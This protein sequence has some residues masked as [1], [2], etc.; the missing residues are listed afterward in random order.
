MNKNLLIFLM[1][2]VSGMVAGIS[3]LFP[4]ANYFI[5]AALTPFFLFIYRENKFWRLWLGVFLYSLFFS[6]II[7]SASVFEPLFILS[8]A[9]IY[10]LAGIV[11]WGV[12]KIMPPLFFWLTAPFVFVFFEF[13]RSSL[14]FI[15]TY[16]A[17]VGY[18]LGSTWFLPLSKILGVWGLTFVVA[19]VNLLFVWIIT[20]KDKKEKLK[21][22]MVSIIILIFIIGMSVYLKSNQ[23][24]YGSRFL[25]IAVIS[26]SEDD[27]NRQENFKAEVYNFENTNSP[28]IDGFLLGIKSE[29]K[30]KISQPVDY[31][32]FPGN[33]IDIDRKNDTDKESFNKWGITN[34]GAF[35]RFYREI[36]K[37][38]QTNVI[39]GLNTI[40][41]GKK[42][43]SILLFDKTGEI[44]GIYH[45]SD[46]MLGSEYWPFDWIP[47]YWRWIWKIPPGLSF[48]YNP[49]YSPNETPFSLLNSK[50]FKIGVLICIESHNPFN[51]YKIFRNG[52]QLI[53]APSN[54]DWFVGPFTQHYKWLNLNALRVNSFYYN[55]PIIMNGKE[56]YAGI[57]LP[58]GTYDINYNNEQDI[59]IW[60][61]TIRI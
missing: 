15:P 11:F 32:F 20:R 5:L 46:L 58:N 1:P 26:L 61:K 50:D 48:R 38:Y 42:Y 43:N 59:I 47:F 55:L 60:Q 23:G 33:V 49:N 56:N 37:D 36:A 51:F 10:C 40:E 41:N 30:N 13:L 6:I 3:M 35:I 27:I 39:A 57:I 12:K 54:N 2:I 45:K 28:I 22:L 31:I 8:T 29:L 17:I 24:N 9:F 25:N 7:A 52:A 19:T 21:S 16:I 4:S 44:N 53:F 18:S 14:S 34:N